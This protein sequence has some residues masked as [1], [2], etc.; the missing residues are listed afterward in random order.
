MGTSSISME[1]LSNFN[2]K[3]HLSM[4]D[5]VGKIIELNGGFSRHGA[6]ETG[7]GQVG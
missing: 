1:F 2:G 7:D 3:T 5:F 6:D 4:V